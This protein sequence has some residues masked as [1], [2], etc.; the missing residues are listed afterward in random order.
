MLAGVEDVTNDT[1][2]GFAVF[3]LLVFEGETVFPCRDLV[4]GI[5]DFD[6]VTGLVDNLHFVSCERA[7]YTKHG[8][9]DSKDCKDIHF[10]LHRIRLL[11][12]MCFV[13]YAKQ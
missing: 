3:D 5:F 12:E 6:V 7:A 9:E 10:L 2:F 13:P 11:A 8:H 4:S 1:A